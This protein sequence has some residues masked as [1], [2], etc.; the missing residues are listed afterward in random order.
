VDIETACAFDGRD[1]VVEKL[2]IDDEPDVEGGDPLPIERPVNADERFFAIVDPELDRALSPV[3]SAR[4]SSP[5]DSRGVDGPIEMARDDVAKDEVEVVNLPAG[6][7]AARAARTRASEV[8]GF[9][10][11]EGIEHGR[12]GGIAIAEKACNRPLNVGARS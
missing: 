12:G 4:S 2:V 11:K 1:E 10:L 6:V 5:A 8:I 9:G 3:F 7:E